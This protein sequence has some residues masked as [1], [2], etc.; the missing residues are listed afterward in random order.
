MLAKERSKGKSHMVY[1]ATYNMSHYD[2]S[3]LFLP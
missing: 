3:H 1:T 2:A